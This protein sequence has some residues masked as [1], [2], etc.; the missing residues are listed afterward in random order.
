MSEVTHE[1]LRYQIPGYLLILFIAILVLPFL[2]IPLLLYLQQSW[3]TFIVG[4]IGSAL[5]GIPL[6]AL[7]YDIYDYVWWWRGGYSKKDRPYNII[8]SVV[9][10]HVL[11]KYN[12]EKREK[13]KRMFDNK[14]NV[15]ADFGLYKKNAVQEIG[16]IRRHWAIAHSMGAAITASLLSIILSLIIVSYLSVFYPE[17]L[18]P[19]FFQNSF[20]LTIKI[21]PSYTCIL[22]FT[23]IFWK[24]RKRVI[25]IVEVFSKGIAVSAKRE[26]EQ[27][28]K[29][30]CK[31]ELEEKTT[32]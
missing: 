32:S 7:V 19:D 24:S 12:R 27:I 4:I 31:Y 13:I 10:E 5:A 25:E 6:G 14:L 16:Y 1:V 9:L 28:L 17:W 29:N 15:I 20:L 11:R 22:I 18:T 30:L 23:V 8:A 2:N 3:I 21:L 26:M